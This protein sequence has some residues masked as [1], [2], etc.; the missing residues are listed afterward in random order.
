MSY[1][2]CFVNDNF[3]TL[4]YLYDVRGKNNCATATQQEIA[5]ELGLSR[6]TMNKIMKE[7]RDSKFIEQDGNHVGRYILS[8]VAI[9]VI[10]TFRS[11]D[12]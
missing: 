3:R 6:A 4:A 12:R 8:D 5:D 2:K 1:T 10:E 9:T 11:V 7:L